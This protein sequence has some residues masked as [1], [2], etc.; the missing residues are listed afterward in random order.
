MRLL[1]SL[2]TTKLVLASLDI[3]VLWGVAA[4]I[5]LTRHRLSYYTISINETLFFALSSIAAVLVFRELNL[6]RHKV[7]STGV[8]QS[9][10]LGRGMFW[11]GLLQVVMLFLIKERE[12]LD[13]SRAHIVLYLAGG[14]GALSFV[15][16]ALMKIVDGKLFGSLQGTRRVMI[17]GAGNAGRHL[18]T[19]I[20]QTPELGLSIACF[21]DDDPVKIG[22]RLFGRPIDGPV[23]DVPN[24]VERHHVEEIFIAI[25]SVEYN[26]LLEII[27]FCRKTSL[28]VTVTANH[29]KIVH[30]KINT[31][32]FRLIESMTLRPQFREAS[33][34]TLKQLLDRI[35]AAILLMLLAPLM[36]AIAIA[37]KLGSRGPVLYSTQ[38]VGKG[39]ELFTWYKFRTMV[40][41]RSEDLHRNYVED[42][43][44]NNAATK[45]LDGD[46]RITRVGAFL[47]KYSLDELPQLFN[48]LRGEMSL[49]GPRPCLP[50]EFEHFDEWHRRRFAVTPGIT[51]LWQ[52]FGRN[53]NDVS[54]NDSIILDLYYIQNYSLWL[55][56]KIML[57]TIPI[58][59]FGRGGA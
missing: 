30:N 37:V 59:L 42:I 50:Y 35:G 13:Y 9:M 31:S 17:I 44:R 12:V 53:R 21:V 1:R 39:G 49:I 32:E 41:D 51:G 29:F 56:L 2:G 45:K 28:P 19:R 16:V 10:V 38:V 36:L 5:L 15:R 11:L 23:S 55:D 58:V 43:I 8:H 40:V 7:F 20:Q 27:E 14:W 25:N 6:Y 34:H 26:R 18:A 48:V 4:A 47:R 24:L 22:N 54:F 57:K 52:V 33:G 3:L 46:P